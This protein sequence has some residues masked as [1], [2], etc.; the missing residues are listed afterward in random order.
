MLSHIDTPQHSK[1]HYGPINI[2]KKLRRCAQCM[3]IYICMCADLRLV[4]TTIKI[5]LTRRHTRTQISGVAV[6]GFDPSH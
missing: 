5:Q 1:A 3:P 4:K 2:T 6:R